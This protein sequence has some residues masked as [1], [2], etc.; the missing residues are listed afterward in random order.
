N[1][2]NLGGVPFAVPVVRA[3]S[4]WR[5]ENRQTAYHKKLGI[6]QSFPVEAGTIASYR[7]A[8]HFAEDK[9]KNFAALDLANQLKAE[10]VYELYV[11]FSSSNL[12]PDE[13]GSDGPREAVLYPLVFGMNREQRPIAAPIIQIDR[14]QGEFAGG[15]WVLANFSGQISA[16]AVRMLAELAVQCA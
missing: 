4:Q 16:T 11:R 15:R 3:G 6:T 14:L 2:L 13:S 10:R 1:L 7:A 8:N 5:T 12:I 9:P